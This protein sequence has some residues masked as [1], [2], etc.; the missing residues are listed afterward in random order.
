MKVIK[1]KKRL[2]ILW[3]KIFKMTEGGEWKKGIAERRLSKMK[4]V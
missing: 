3:V 1:I 2:G 4:E